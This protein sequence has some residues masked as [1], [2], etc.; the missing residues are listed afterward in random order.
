M[1]PGGGL[2]QAGW[3]G[4][5]LVLIRGSWR[6]GLRLGAGFVGAAGLCI[7]RRLQWAERRTTASW[8]LGEASPRLDS[9]PGQIPA[10]GLDGLSIYDNWIRYFNRSSTE[11]GLVPR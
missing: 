10:P 4:L 3:A 11:Y 1:G 8:A 7:G 2:S 6:W 5:E 9:S